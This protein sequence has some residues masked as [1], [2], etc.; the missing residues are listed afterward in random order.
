MKKTSLGSL[1]RREGKA[2]FSA[3]LVCYLAKG[4]SGLIPSTPIASFIALSVLAAVA[5]IAAYMLTKN[6]TV[7]GSVYIVLQLLLA[8][9]YFIKSCIFENLFPTVIASLGVF[10]RLDS[11]VGG[12][13]DLSAVVYYLTVICL[14]CYLTA[15]TM[16]QRRWA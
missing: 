2:T 7:G 12:I 4:I 16:Q 13:F 1:V 5:A 9:L 8:L 6:T 11:F 15:K 14:F 10:D 3:L